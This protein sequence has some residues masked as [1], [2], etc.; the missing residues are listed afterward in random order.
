LT[1]AIE[2]VIL[3][4]W[5]SNI[6]QDQEHTRNL[7]ESSAWIRL[8]QLPIPHSSNAV[9]FSTASTLRS[10]RI[11]LIPRAVLK[12]EL[13]ESFAGLEWPITQSILAPA[14]LLRSTRIRRARIDDLPHYASKLVA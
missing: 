8:F 12:T 3:S 14:R 10:L 4:E 5:D 2:K 13:S 1:D 7:K 11:E 6:I 9:T